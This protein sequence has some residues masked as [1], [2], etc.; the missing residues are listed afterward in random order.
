MHIKMSKTINK[1]IKFPEL[2]E[3]KVEFIVPEICDMR[4]NEDGIRF[5]IE[6]NIGTAILMERSLERAKNKICNCIE[7]E[8]WITI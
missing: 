6:G 3:Y 8:E 2:R 5:F 1:I 4:G 7:V